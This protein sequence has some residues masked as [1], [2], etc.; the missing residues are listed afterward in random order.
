MELGSLKVQVI[1]K[2]IKNI[3]LSVYPPQGSVRLAAPRSVAD[4]TI[5]LFLV[6]KLGWIRKQQR[7]FQKQD[8]EGAKELMNRESHYFLGKRYLLKVIE[9]NDIP[10]ASVS[11]KQL[12]IRARP[13]TSTEN[14]HQILAQWYRRQLKEVLGPLIEKWKKKIGVRPDKWSI[15]KMRTK[16][17][18]CNTDSRKL[19]FNLELAKKP[20]ECIEFIVVHE[21][22]HLKERRHSDRFVGLVEKYLPDWKKRKRHLNSLE[23]G[24]LPDR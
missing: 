17:G 22:V 10:S 8:R 4:E 19:T 7:Q 23:I 18:T 3:H 11:G 1:R 14:R 9:Q 16:W 2:D 5:R 20:L 15:R 21:L 24:T 6:S 12:I 13:G